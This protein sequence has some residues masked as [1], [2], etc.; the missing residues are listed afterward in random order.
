[1]QHS[2]IINLH[3]YIECNCKKVDDKLTL[4]QALTSLLFVSTASFAFPLI[5][6]AGRKIERKRIEKVI[7]GLLK[8]DVH[9]L[10]F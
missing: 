9:P 5:L 6:Q 8:N 2:I 3:F 10:I 7:I 1:M 4:G